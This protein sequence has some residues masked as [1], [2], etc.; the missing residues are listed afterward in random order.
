[1]QKLL[2]LAI[3]SVVFLLSFA[4]FLCLFPSLVFILGG[5]FL[6]VLHHPAYLVVGGGAWAITIGITLYTQFDANYYSK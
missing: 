1:M 2:R 3:L 4:F 5:E 6:A